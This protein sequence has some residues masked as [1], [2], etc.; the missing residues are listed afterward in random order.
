MHAKQLPSCASTAV[1]LPAF[2]PTNKIM[3]Y[4]LFGHA[5]YAVAVLSAYI[6]T[7]PIRVHQN[8]L[9]FWA[10]VCTE[11]PSAVAAAAVPFVRFPLLKRHFP[12]G[13]L[14]V[15]Q[16]HDLSP[17]KMHNCLPFFQIFIYFFTV[18]CTHTHENRQTCNTLLHPFERLLLS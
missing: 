16:A 14:Y 5:H 11:P 1:Q 4:F 10:C 6:E 3:H 12:N 17:S 9:P 7:P 8:A 2:L 13:S 18:W 15:C